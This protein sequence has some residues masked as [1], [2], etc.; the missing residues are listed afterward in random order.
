M[1]SCIYGG[2]VSF[3]F[4][5]TGRHDGFIVMK[6][7]GVRLIYVSEFYSFLRELEWTLDNKVGLGVQFGLGLD[8]QYL[9]WKEEICEKYFVFCAA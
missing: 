1:A 4:S 7:C 9:H 3:E 5:V 6:E 8:L 2:T